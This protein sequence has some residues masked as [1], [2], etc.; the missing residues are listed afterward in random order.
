MVHGGTLQL[1]W[2]QDSNVEEGEDDLDIL[3]EHLLTLHEMKAR[4]NLHNKRDSQHKGDM[5]LFLQS[6]TLPEHLR[7][8]WKLRCEEIPSIKCDIK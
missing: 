6:M 2:L 3:L 8:K 4:K 5:I 7:E 1:L